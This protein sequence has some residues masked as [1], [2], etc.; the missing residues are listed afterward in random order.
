MSDFQHILFYDGNC[1]L[2]NGAI[3]FLLKRDQQKQLMVSPLQS[4]AAKKYLKQITKPWP[5]SII[6]YSNNEIFIESTAVIRAFACLSKWRKIALLLLIIPT[7]IRNAVYLWIA[8]NRY[9]WFG[10][11]DS[12]LLP[13]NYQD[14]ILS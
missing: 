12:C 6:F 5:D 13:T 11:S 8:R 1:L 14:Q 3:K 9:D 2:C 10:K 4:E 7:F